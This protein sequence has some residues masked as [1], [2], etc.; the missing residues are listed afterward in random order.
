MTTVTII[1][2]LKTPHKRPQNPHTPSKTSKPSNSSKPSTLKPSKTQ[3][4]LYGVVAW[5]W[6][7]LIL[8]HCQKDWWILNAQLNSKGKYQNSQT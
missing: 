3:T 7:V 8:N 1:T 4:N 5:F 2:K 6:C